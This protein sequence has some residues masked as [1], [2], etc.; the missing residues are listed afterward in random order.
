MNNGLFSCPLSSFYQIISFSVEIILSF[1]YIP[2][3]QIA[4][5]PGLIFK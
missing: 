4:S 3:V 2:H 1:F 5:S